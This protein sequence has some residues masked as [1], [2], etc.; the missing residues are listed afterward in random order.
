[1]L[2]VWISSSHRTIGHPWYDAAFSGFLYVVLH[3]V[4]MKLMVCALV[5]QK[6]LMQP[7]IPTETA[8][9]VYKRYLRLEP[10]HTEE[11]IAY[12]KSKV[13]TA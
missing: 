10:M 6:F 9:R 3:T 7:G 8:V 4:M 1:M 2:D 5:W 12:L 13:C 11:Y